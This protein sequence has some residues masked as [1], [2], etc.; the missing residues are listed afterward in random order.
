MKK[1]KNVL[2]FALACLVLLQTAVNERLLVP[3]RAAESD[4]NVTIFYGYG[5]QA[6]TANPATNVMVNDVNDKAYY[7]TAKYGV[8]NG[9]FNDSGSSLPVNRYGQKNAAA[10]IVSADI[11]YGDLK[12]TMNSYSAATIYL[13]ADEKSLNTSSGT[14]LLAFGGSNPWKAG[15]SSGVIRFYHIADDLTIVYHYADEVTLSINGGEGAV[16]S[17]ETGFPGYSVTNKETNVYT[18]YSRPRTD[19]KEG[20]DTTITYPAGK[21]VNGA[22][23]L[24]GTEKISVSAEQMQ[25]DFYVNS[26][27]EITTDATDAILKFTR[28][29]SGMDGTLKVYKINSNISMTVTYEGEDPKEPLL[30]KVVGANHTSANVISSTAMSSYVG[31]ENFDAANGVVTFQN[32]YFSENFGTADGLAFSAY[33]VYGTVESVEVMIGTHT[34]TFGNEDGD[35]VT[36]GRWISQD[37]K[38]VKA[39]PGTGAKLKY[40]HNLSSSVYSFRFWEISED[41]TIIFHY[42]TIQAEVVNT[43]GQLTRIAYDDGTSVFTKIPENA[44][45]V[46]NTRLTLETGYMR[47]G[48]NYYCYRVKM[49]AAGSALAGVQ[50]C[51][52]K[53]AETCDLIPADKKSGTTTVDTLGTFTYSYNTGSSSNGSHDMYYIR[54]KAQNVDKLIFKPII[55]GDLNRDDKVSATDLISLREVLTGAAESTTLAN[56]NKDDVIDVCDLVHMKKYLESQWKRLPVSEIPLPL[57]MLQVLK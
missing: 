19:I 2:A 18:G 21:T 52:E 28:G 34:V 7:S 36:S 50:I 1:R 40:A 35:L 6:G 54:V 20:F 15:S 55:Y 25:A 47:N 10:T 33:S 11:L 32:E 13:S 37:Y 42:T 39:M 8:T 3:V 45:T 14:K 43:N 24:I 57:G 5:G 56:H 46:E 29:V 48:A 41:I 49:E 17:S 51:A 27:Y 16:Y 22:T 31:A 9:D 12:Y 4:H 26:A 44:V 53:V 38:K 30:L 23:I